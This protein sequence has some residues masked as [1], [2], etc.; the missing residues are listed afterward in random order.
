MRKTLLLF[1]L[2]MAVTVKFCQ[3]QIRYGNP[4]DSFYVQF[5]PDS[6]LSAH[7]SWS[8][9]SIDTAG[10]SV[11]QLGNTVKPFFSDSSQIYGMMTDTLQPYPVNSNGSFVVKWNRVFNTILSFRHKY[12]TTP[13]KDGGIVEFSTD[14][15]VWYNVRGNCYDAQL[16]QALLFDSMYTVT[17]TLEDGEPAF[18]GTSSG[19]I[20]S[21]IQFFDG[22]PVRVTGACNGL[23]QLLY[24][25]FRFVSDSVA[26]SLD[27]WIIS[28]FKVR[29]D[30]YGSNVNDIKYNVLHIAPNP[31][32]TGIFMFPALEQSDKFRIIIT[33]VQGRVVKDQ[34]YTSRLDLGAYP[35]GVYFYRVSNGTVQYN[36]K[37]IRE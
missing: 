24:L 14:S 16:Y 35:S 3:A 4:I 18:S 29:T 23:P 34:P 13:G 6:P 27:G 26:D 11:W 21:Y 17:D 10:M 33:D 12:Q 25:R 5:Q 32:A 1:L 22:L 28:Q 19:W 37:L 20:T 31:S 36:G 30:Y 2:L 9:L 7:S 15:V 8:A